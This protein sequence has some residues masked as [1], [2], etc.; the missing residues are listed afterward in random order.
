[1]SLLR[2]ADNTSALQSIVTLA[3]PRHVFQQ[4][5][6]RKQRP[7]THPFG[8][9]QQLIRVLAFLRQPPANMQLQQRMR[10]SAHT[11]ASK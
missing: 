5:H 6:V 3:E 8:G 9:V 10:A 11:T 4:G 7:D 1:M 2:R